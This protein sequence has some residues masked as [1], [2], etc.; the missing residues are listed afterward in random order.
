MRRAGRTSLG[1]KKTTSVLR[2]TLT[3]GECVRA[4]VWQTIK[5]Q[6]MSDQAG[7]FRGMVDCFRQTIRK[8]GWRAGLFAGVSAPLIGVPPIYAL[9]FWGFDLGKQIATHLFEPS[10]HEP[11]ASLSLF[12][13]VFAGGFS[14]LP[15]AVILVPGDLIKIHLQL[16]RNRPG[17][18]RFDSIWGSARFIVSQH[19]LGGLYRGGLLT[20]SR[21][22][23]ASIAYYSVYEVLKR[24]LPDPS[25]SASI[26]LAGGLA[27]VA[28]WSVAVP[29]DVIKTRYQT[30]PT[31]MSVAAII[32]DIANKEGIGGFFRGFTPA[33]LR[34][35][36]SNA[37]IF[38]KSQPSLVALH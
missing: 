28:N 14:A 38:S 23:P 25:S 27:G 19:G 31:R 29:P 35:F 22:I 8:R 7:Q 16:E 3:N 36:P 18:P 15:G 32:K 9:Y 11:G 12:S 6:L 26:L 4:C 10:S 2:V 34:A 13:L 21:E 24:N 1:C 33:V 5:V 37:A 30:S 17:P 20:L